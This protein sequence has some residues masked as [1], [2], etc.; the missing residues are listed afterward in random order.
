MQPA[1]QCLIKGCPDAIAPR[2]VNK[3]EE[4]ELNS[5]YM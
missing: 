2:S 3:D 5:A 1:I 4:E